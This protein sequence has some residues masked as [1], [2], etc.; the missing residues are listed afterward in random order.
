MK[1]GITRKPIMII[2]LTVATCTVYY[3]YW[4]YI[5]TKE[6]KEFTGDENLDPV[7]TVLFIIITCG[8]YSFFWYKKMAAI[9]LKDMS[10]KVGIETDESKIGTIF[11]LSIFLQIM[12]LYML[13]TKLNYI[14]EK[15]E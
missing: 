4:F 1:K 9:V 6:I 12:A 8:I 10:E 3:Y 13:Q 14:W 7:K 2:I 5:T 15:S 11:I